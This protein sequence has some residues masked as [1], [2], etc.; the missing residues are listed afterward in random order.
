[1]LPG[2]VAAAIAWQLLRL[3][4]ESYVTRTVKHASDIDNLFALVL[5]L[6][7]FLYAA[8]LIVVLCAEANAVRV[9]RLYPRAL[10]TPLTD[11]VELTPGDEKAYTKQAAAQRSKGFEQIDVSFDKDAPRS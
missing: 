1:M 10:L 3:G 11:N 7:A 2:A 4:G 8:A 9:D 5:G 6:I